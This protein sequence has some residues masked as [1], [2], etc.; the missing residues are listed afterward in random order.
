MYR[1]DNEYLVE[2]THDQHL[3]AR[4]VSAP[5]PPRR[6]IEP[7]RSR[8]LPWPRNLF[9]ELASIEELMTETAH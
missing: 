4:P 7:Y 1:H 2:A 3:F 9:G 5:E 6:A 8:A